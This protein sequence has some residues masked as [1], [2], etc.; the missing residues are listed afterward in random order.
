MLSD[1]FDLPCLTERER[2]CQMRR[3]K[4]GK[5]LKSNTKNVQSVD[6]EVVS[7][8]FKVTELTDAGTYRCEASNKLGSVNT[9]ATLDVQ[10]TI[11]LI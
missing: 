10:S 2:G 9:E 6:K 1:V 4:N 3:F 5:D 7:L 11:V 8:T